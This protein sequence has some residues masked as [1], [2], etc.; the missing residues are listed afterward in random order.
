MDVEVLPI[1]E[2][3]KIPREAHIACLDRD[4]IQFPLILRHWLHGDYFYPLGMDQMKKVSDFFVDNKISVPEKER[5]WILASGKKIVWI[6]GHRIDHR[7]RIR[8]NT[9]NVLLLRSQTQVAP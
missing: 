1:K 7:F 3:D 5:T 4:E 2:L 9:K 6:V 8:E